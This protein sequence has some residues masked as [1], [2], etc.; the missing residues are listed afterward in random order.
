VSRVLVLDAE[1]LTSLARERG[2]RFRETRAAMEAARLLNR[3]VVTPAVVLAEVYRGPRHNQVV[4][5]CLS[6]ETGISVRDTDRTFARLVGGVL[7]GAAAG[8]SDM[9]DAHAVAAAVETGGGVILTADE[10]DVGRLAARYPTIVVVT[11]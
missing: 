6:R 10:D 9:A 2:P 11:I 1:A 7:S 4:D 3:D 8:S 5:A